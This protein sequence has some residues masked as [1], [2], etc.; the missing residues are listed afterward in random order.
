MSML[1]QNDIK[2]I[3]NL[4][5]DVSTKKD[6][7]RFETRVT[8]RFDQIDKKFVDLFDFLDKDV[9]KHKRRI[10][11]IEENLGITPDLSN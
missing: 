3:K 2:I 1:S 11:T 9:M 6:L 7:K 4:L 5:K 8:K 10:K